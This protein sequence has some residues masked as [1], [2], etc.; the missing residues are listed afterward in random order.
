MGDP[1][2]LLRSC[3]REPASTCQNHPEAAKWTNTRS[4]KLHHRNTSTKHMVARLVFDLKPM[5][6]VLWARG[7]LREQGFW[8]CPGAPRHDW[9]T[10]GGAQDSYCKTWDCVTSNDGPRRWE[11][12]NRDLLNFSFAKPLPRVPGDP[13][14][15]CESCNYAQVKIRFNPKKIKQEGIRSALSATRGILCCP[16][17]RV[18]FLCRSYRNS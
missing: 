17:K 6:N 5:V 1:V 12:G 16:K 9:K 14:F 8:A 18:L 2:T 10:C 3:Q 13:T 11:V 7:Y 4:A 15:S